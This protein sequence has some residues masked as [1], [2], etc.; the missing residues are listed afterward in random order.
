M[1]GDAIRAQRQRAGLTQ[2]ELAHT[3]RISVRTL[4]E[5]EAGRVRRPRPRTVRMLAEALGLTDFDQTIATITGTTPQAVPFGR[6]SRSA[7]PD[8]NVGVD[9]LRR[10]PIPA[11]LPH[12]SQHFTARERE[13]E[14]MDSWLDE[15]ENR[16]LGAPVL[17][18]TGAAGVGKS[19]C[20]VQWGHRTA[21]RFPGGQLYV[22]LA[23]D[24]SPSPEPGDAMRGL[25]DALGVPPAE[26]P[27]DAAVQA[28]LFR[29]M[30]SGQRML[31]LI[32]NAARIEQVRPLL[33]GSASCAVVVTSREP[34]TELIADDGAHLQE[35]LPFGEE[36]ARRFLLS[37]L[38]P[39]RL[40]RDIWAVTEIIRRC[41]G[42]PRLLSMLCARAAV[43]PT[44]DPT[45]I[46]EEMNLFETRAAFG[47]SAPTAPLRQSVN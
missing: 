3:A 10:R 1:L 37:R 43:Q 39:R 32:D 24:R 38:D 14:R 15:A 28:A 42:S 4:G 34:L 7:E 22:D 47:E 45:R 36:D 31:I 18:L 13:M 6:S 30:V 23:N 12:G 29:S 44:V 26:I 27:T 35:I 33:P 19:A 21:G 20:A 5:I 16:P 25:L 41:A 11:Q 2:E 46:V 17:I 9:G 8:R 40:P